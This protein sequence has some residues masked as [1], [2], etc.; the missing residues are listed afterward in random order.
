MALRSQTA[1]LILAITVV[2]M[3]ADVRHDHWKGSAPGTLTADEQGIVFTESGKKATEHSRTWK[4]DDVQELILTS[5]TIEIRSYEDAKWQGGRDREYKFTGLTEGAAQALYP[6]LRQQLG[7]KFVAALADPAVT[8]VWTVGAKLVRGVGG[9]EGTLLVGEDDIVYKS[10]E[11]GA[12]RT[13]RIADI[14]TVSSG[15]PHE[16]TVAVPERTSTEEYRFQLK[17]P[18]MEHRFN[19]LWRK[20]NT[21]KGLAILSPHGNHQND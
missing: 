16:L 17:R 6:V 14:A 19:A 21:R 15:H 2:G 10:N 9:S 12:S 20:V 5:M 11:P 3:A 18:L 1:A 8:P 13:W 7:L 4:Y